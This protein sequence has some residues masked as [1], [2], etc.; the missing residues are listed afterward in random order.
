M[1]SYKSEAVLPATDESVCAVLKK[2]KYL[3]YQAEQRCLQFLKTAAHSVFEEYR[4]KK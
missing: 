3:I 1:P 4:R 2:G